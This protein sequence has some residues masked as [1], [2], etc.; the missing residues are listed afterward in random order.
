MTPEQ[1]LNHCGTLE[2]FVLENTKEAFLAKSV[3]DVFS[4]IRSAL[5]EQTMPRLPL[6]VEELKTM[7]LQ[8]WVWIE[9]LVPSK[10]DILQEPRSAYYKKVEGVTPGE[11]FTCGY[12]GLLYGFDY[13]KYGEEWLAY[14]LEPSAEGWRWRWHSP[15]DAPAD[16]ADGTF[17]AAVKLLDG[18]LP[19]N[20]FRCFKD[21]GDGS[22][23]G[24]ILVD[25]HGGAW[26]Y[27]RDLF[28][29]LNWTELPPPLQAHVAYSDHK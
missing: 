21:D 2:T 17:L 20:G 13:D 26:D 12:P 19:H 11:T 14:H 16:L 9:I 24:H 28:E 10:W 6:T 4:V 18:Q 27:D 5:Q 15:D 29:M 22:C 23:I 1:A 25:F 3:Q 7:P 8:K